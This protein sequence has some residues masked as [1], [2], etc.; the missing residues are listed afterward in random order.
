MIRKKYE[1]VRFFN[2]PILY[3]IQSKKGERVSI[4]FSDIANADLIRLEAVRG[5]FIDFMHNTFSFMQKKRRFF[6]TLVG[7]KLLFKFITKLLNTLFLI[8]NKISSC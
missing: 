4:P 7:V 8:F 3:I 2:V 6:F 1:K 5:D